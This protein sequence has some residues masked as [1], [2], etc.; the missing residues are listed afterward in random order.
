MPL[1][2]TEA[3]TL[4]RGRTVLTEGLT[5]LSVCG[6][7]LFHPLLV[8]DVDHLE[9]PLV[10]HHLRQRQSLRRLLLQQFR[11]EVPCP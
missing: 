10:L 2:M 11:D 5:V 3:V 7:S 9:D 4:Q 1:A 8:L 6:F